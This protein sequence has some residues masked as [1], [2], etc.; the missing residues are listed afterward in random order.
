M[1]AGR[2]LGTGFLLRSKAQEAALLADRTFSPG[3]ERH[4]GEARRVS[5]ARVGV[6]RRQK[7]VTSSDARYDGSH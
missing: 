1:L 4:L 3:K 6:G 5:A 2:A 7:Q